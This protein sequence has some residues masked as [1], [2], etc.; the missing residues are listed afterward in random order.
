MKKKAK[1]VKRFKKSFVSPE[2]EPEPAPAL[3]DNTILAPI[4]A[5]RDPGA[6]QPL[7]DTDNIPNPLKRHWWS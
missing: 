2:P 6:T 4:D 7:A 5:P 3:D 1:K